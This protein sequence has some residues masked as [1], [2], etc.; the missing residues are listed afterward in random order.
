MAHF[1]N[2]HPGF[3]FRACP[4][5]PRIAKPC[6]PR[7]FDKLFSWVVGPHTAPNTL[8]S[9]FFWLIWANDMAVEKLPSGVGAPRCRP[10]GFAFHQADSDCSKHHCPAQ[11]T[12]PSS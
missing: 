9:L 2:T 7:A 4:T 12:Y 1:E 8:Q 6:R 10:H 3:G 11:K 5:N